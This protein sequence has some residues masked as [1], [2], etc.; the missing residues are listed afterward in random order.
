MSISGNNGRHRP[1]PGTASPTPSQSWSILARHAREEVLPL[2]LQQLCSDRDRVSSLVTV[3]SSNYNHMNRILLL[4]MSRQRMT[5]ETVNHLLRFGV[6]RNLRGYIRGFAWGQNNP[7]HPI[8]KE[9]VKPKGFQHTT[10]HHHH[11]RRVISG[12]RVVVNNNHGDHAN[13]N[14]NP[15]HNKLQSSMHMT[16]RVPHYDNQT[17]QTQT[18]TGTGT[19]MCMLTSD[20]VNVLDDIFLERSRIERLATSV[21]EGV[22]RGVSG[23]P[24]RDVVV[25]GR[26]VGVLALKFW[27]DAL[28]HDEACMAASRQGLEALFPPQS[29]TSMKRGGGAAD[30]RDLQAG[31]RIR[32]I[33]GS[34]DPLAMK[35]SLDGLAP[36]STLVLSV[37]LQGSE[38]TEVAT[39]YLYQWLCRDTG[40]KG[41]KRE[42]IAGHHMFLVTGNETL[43]QLKPDSTFLVP[44][45]SQCEAFGSF[46]AGILFV[47]AS[48]GEFIVYIYILHTYVVHFVPT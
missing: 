40:T 8:P 28:C 9:Q 42:S 24:L 30:T 20:G 41:Y 13:H 29:N 46:A 15:N 45:H 12:G 21:R 14:N 32:F 44:A 34:S 1:R 16:F 7:K 26:G 38:E 33:S 22:M 10:N 25:V 11:H 36:A 6:S 43:K 31:R 27:A 3:H 4:D 47:S 18:T 5:L 35:R 39:R 48:H 37:A 23:Q 17:S 2:P 19:G